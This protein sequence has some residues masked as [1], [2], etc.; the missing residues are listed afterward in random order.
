[1]SR[2]IY[3]A[4]TVLLTLLSCASSVSLAAEGEIYRST[5]AEGHVIFSDKASESAKPVKVPPTNTMTE[6][7]VPKIKPVAPLEPGATGAIANTYTRLEIVAPA[8]STTVIAP[9]GIMAMNVALFPALQVGHRLQL[10]LD[11]V[12]TGNAIAGEFSVPAVPRGP[13]TLEVQV[14]DER[15]QVIQSTSTVEVQVVRPGKGGS[16]PVGVG[17][18][19]H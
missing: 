7:D 11:G 6:V 2:N 10:L 19:Q 5:D 12:P 17:S 16:R 18:G 14:I 13:H 8:N 9:N 3:R 1:M 4:R 15:G